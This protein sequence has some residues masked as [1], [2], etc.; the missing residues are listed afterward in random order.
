MN[1]GRFQ[2]DTAR[3]PALQSWS[4]VIVLVIGA[5]FFVWARV[6]GPRART[7]ESKT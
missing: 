1:G 4:R 3:L 2:N 6:T 7:F 5:P